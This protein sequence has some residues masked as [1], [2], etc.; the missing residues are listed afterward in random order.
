MTEAEQKQL[1]EA[2]LAANCSEEKIERF[3]IVVEKSARQW[4]II[5]FPSMVAFIVLALFGF[6]LIYSLTGDIRTIANSIDPNMGHHMARMTDSMQKMDAT[7]SNMSS[8]IRSLPPM[9]SHIEKM[10]SS[11]RAMTYTNDQMR[12]SMATMTH[13][14]ARPMSMF[15]TFMPW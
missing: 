15:N 7:M 4:Q 14:V 5:V 11:M 9:L 13:Q 2:G 10:D 6:Y 8:D 1:V 3:L 12:H